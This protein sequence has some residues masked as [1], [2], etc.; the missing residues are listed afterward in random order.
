[1]FEFK[2]SRFTVFAALRFSTIIRLCTHVRTYLQ[3]YLADWILNDG[4]MHST[5]R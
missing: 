3:R 5:A 2:T 1:M 4:N